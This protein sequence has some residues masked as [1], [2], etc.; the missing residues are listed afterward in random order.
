MRWSRTLAVIAAVL[1]LPAV[2]GAAPPNDGVE[3]A[4]PV[5]VHQ[6]L[7]GTLI[8]ATVVADPLDS[9]CGAAIG[10]VWYRI[11]PSETQTVIIDLAAAGKLDA[12]VGVFV[13]Q[14]SKRT[15]LGCRETDAK[16]AVT[17]AFLGH[18]DAAYLISVSRTADSPPDAFMLALST[19]TPAPATPGTRLPANGVRSTVDAL[20]NPFDAWFYAMTEGQTYKVNLL[21]ATGTSSCARLVI[22]GPDAPS[23]D[24]SSTGR[25]LRCGGYLTFTPRAG[26]SGTYSFLIIATAPRQAYRLR[27]APVEADDLAPGV[28]LLNATSARGTLSSRGIDLTDIYRFDVATPSNVRLILHDGPRT[29]FD[30]VLVTADGKLVRCECDRVGSAEIRLPL[31]PGRYLVAVRARNGAGGPYRLY[32]LARSE[33]RTALTAPGHTFAPG[34]GVPLTA[35]TTPAVG[36]GTTSIVLER[37]DPFTG[38]HYVALLRTLSGVAAA[39]TP[40]SEGRYRAI[41]YY[42][43]SPTEAPSTSG[44]LLFAVEAPLGSGG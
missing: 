40:P 35:T 32:R 21:A 44:Y 1:A 29:Q 19:P 13:E 9:A 31:R 41:A 11:E 27:V 37:F 30:L 14:R 36:S 43:G 15:R 12:S 16:G 4:T 6:K 20:R 39:F 18:P 38:W 24:R 33:T 22:V 2:A 28:P 23:L 7:A 8:D 10:S 25:G 42:R 3:S 34:A 5:Q 26:K 17:V